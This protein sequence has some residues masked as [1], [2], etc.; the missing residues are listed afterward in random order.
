MYDIL[1][2]TSYLHDFPF[3]S[4]FSITVSND[5][6]QERSPISDRR[7]T[8]VA[9][10]FSVL[11][12]SYTHL[13]VYKRQVCV[14]ERGGERVEP[15]LILVI[16][17]KTKR[18]SDCSRM[19]RVVVLLENSWVSERNIIRSLWLTK[20]LTKSIKNVYAKVYPELRLRGVYDTICIACLL[21]TSRCV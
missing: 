3:H 7:S 1:L 8:K 20:I 18:L 21:Y 6:F 19:K 12:V 11:P 5:R 14:R 9:R 2:L 4:G 15:G 13:D 10:L 16:V 17:L